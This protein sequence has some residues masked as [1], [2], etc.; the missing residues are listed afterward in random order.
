MN[1]LQSTN[2]GHGYAV[3]GEIVQSTLEEVSMAVTAAQKA[4]P[5][6]KALSIAER[7]FYYE[8]LLPI[9]E[10]RADEIARMQTLETGKTITQSKNDVAGDLE[11]IKHVLTIAQRYLKSDVVDDLA[12]QT[13]MVVFEPYGVMAAIMPWNY[14]SSNFFI[15]TTHALLAGN[16][17]VAKH[18]EECPLTSKLLNELFSEAG[19]PNGV[20]TMLYGNGHVGKMLVEQ[21]IN[22][23]HFTGSSKVGH[24]L[25]KLAGSK[26]IPVILEMGGSSPGI[27][28]AD[29]DLHSTVNSICN[30]RYRNCG[31]ICCALKR[32]F[33]QQE[34]Y[35]EIV[36][37]LANQVQA[38]KLGDPLKDDTDIGSLVAERQCILLEEQV[39]DAI[40]K[41]AKIVCGG[42]RSEELPG[43]YFEPTLLTHITPDMRVYREEVFGPVL[44]VVPFNT[45]EE[46]LELANNS[47]YGLSAFVY[48]NDLER[49]QRVASLL[50]AG[51]VS[52]NGASYFTDNA[53]FGGYKNSGMGSN[54]GKYGFTYVTHMKTV[55]IPK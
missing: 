19:F 48:T 18:S 6:W 2:P 32:L 3:I 44:T 45:E 27:V 10:R 7:I 49:A 28:F 25:Y 54:G 51:N 24:E 50:E 46:A 26:F 38:L 13:T 52:I 30:E 43:A 8:K 40:Y 33:V 1:K 39:K 37:K 36:N 11:W 21:N 55:A 14:P 12:D 41:G 17:I 20:F 9:Y 47:M 15:S 22:L 23:L 5:T 16:T 4:F 53:P 34:R 42:K 35:D 29:A 31:Q